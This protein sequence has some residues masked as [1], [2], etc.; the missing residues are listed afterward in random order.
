[1]GIVW[2]C[3]A[4]NFQKWKCL[5]NDKKTGD[6]EAPYAASEVVS[7]LVGELHEGE[8]L[9]KTGGCWKVKTR[10]HGCRLPP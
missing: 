9:R 6:L 1:M 10:C 3:G 5:R 4:L 7:V 8:C 2:M